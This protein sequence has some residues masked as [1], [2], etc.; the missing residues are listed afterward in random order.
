MHPTHD[1]LS[2]SNCFALPAK[3]FRP[4]PPRHYLPE[5]THSFRFLLFLL[6]SDVFYHFC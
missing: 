1:T 6:V 5:S 4:L 3:S 2:K